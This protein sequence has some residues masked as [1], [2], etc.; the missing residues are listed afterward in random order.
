MQA[1]WLRRGAVNVGALRVGPEIYSSPKFTPIR[2]LYQ[3]RSPQSPSG[4]AAT[5]LPDRALPNPIFLPVRPLLLKRPGTTPYLFSPCALYECK[6]H[7][8][9][10]L[11]L[12]A[13]IT[14]FR[15]FPNRYPRL[16]STLPTNLTDPRL[17]AIRYR[18]QSGG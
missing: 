3:L 9:M 8:R 2:Q 4:T 1:R 6:I 14:S 7:Y 12:N 10:A 18:R 13:M 15:D 11:Y 5:F 17:P 16:Y